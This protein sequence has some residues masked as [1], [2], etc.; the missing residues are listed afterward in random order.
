MLTTKALVLNRNWI[1]I[2]V[3]SVRTAI[4]LVYRG[5]ARVIAPD[6]YETHTFESWAD[7]RA[8]EGESCIRTVSLRLRIPEVIVLMAYD[9]MPQMKVPFT[10]KNIYRR[11][12]YTCQY[13]GA[14]PGSRELSI[15]HIV[16]RSSGGKSTWTNCVLACTTCNSVKANRSIEES[17]LGLRK[18][19]EKPKWYPYIT[20]P[21]MERKQS[22]ERF[23]SDRYWDVTLEE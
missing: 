7:L 21:I 17:G 19:P 4:S 2:H 15:D 1:P 8:A 11:D 10:R 16:P 14:K 23:I 5:I 13:C 22:W 18:L 20:I 6:T 3:T 9:K 12:S